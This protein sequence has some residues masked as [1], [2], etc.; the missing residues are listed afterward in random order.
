MQAE[1]AALDTRANATPVE[2]Q[3]ALFTV[4][5]P[6]VELSSDP[7]GRIFQTTGQYVG[8]LWVED[9]VS[10]P[11]GVVYGPAQTNQPPVAPPSGAPYV[12]LV[13]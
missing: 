12:P 2:P 8:A 5:F 10:C 7:H 11:G 13:Y 1:L 4:N 3:Y 9:G 6:G